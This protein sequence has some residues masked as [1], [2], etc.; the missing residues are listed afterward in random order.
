MFRSKLPIFLQTLLSKDE[1]PVVMSL[2]LTLF[3]HIVLQN[4][5]FFWTFMDQVA[6]DTHTDLNSLIQSLFTVWFDSMDSMTQPERRKLSALALASL[7]P[8]NVSVVTENIGSIISVCVEVLHDVCRVPVDEEAS[9]QLDALVINDGDENE[10]ALETEHDKRK[11][12]LSK[13]DP[14]HSVPLKDFI[15]SQLN[16]CQRL[17]GQEAFHR[18][19]EQVD[20][21]IMT[22]LQHFMK[23]S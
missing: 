6:S 3:G 21:D 5:E 19:M 15:Y 18:L 2:Y 11:R 17:H 9:I 10:E 4:Q 1:H 23:N 16:Q 8:V 7:L 20:P 22:Q 12:A 14:V 13:R